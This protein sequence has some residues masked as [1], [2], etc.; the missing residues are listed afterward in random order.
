MWQ[1]VLAGTLASIFYAWCLESV[2]RGFSPYVAG[3]FLAL[4]VAVT[5]TAT[6]RTN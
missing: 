6:D 4:A 1:R 5:F 3:F 2:L